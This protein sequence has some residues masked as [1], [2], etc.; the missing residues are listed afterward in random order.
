MV[1]WLRLH[2]PNAG[3]LCLTP[4]WGTK[5]HMPQL[6]VCMPKLRF[7][8]LQLRFCMLHRRLKIPCT[9]A[10]TW[11][12]CSGHQAPYGTHQWAH[13][14]KQGSP[15]WTTSVPHMGPFIWRTCI[16]TSLTPKIYPT[17]MLGNGLFETP[18]RKSGE[19]SWRVCLL[20]LLILNKTC[21][22][23][24]LFL[25]FFLSFLIFIYLAMLGLSCS[26]QNLV[27]WPGI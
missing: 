22:L 19:D 5:S 20:F 7:Y 23:K 9:V 8:M 25:S 27:L 2:I 17:K 3:G 10:K 15:S 24:L 18:A 11:Q 6:R 14:W 13:A 26:M 1:Q 21:T 4:G 12:S 16:L